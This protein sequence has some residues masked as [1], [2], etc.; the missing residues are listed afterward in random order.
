MLRDRIAQLEAEVA[1]F[2]HPPP[3][4][5][6][7]RAAMREAAA[8]EMQVQDLKEAMAGALE[9]KVYPPV[10]LPAAT[11]QTT[12]LDLTRAFLTLHAKNGECD[13]ESVSSVVA[14]YAHALHARCPGT[15]TAARLNA[16]I[17][18]DAIKIR[19]AQLG[20]LVD[21]H[22]GLDAARMDAAV[23]SGE[24]AR[25]VPIVAHL[26]VG[27][28][29]ATRRNP[30]PSRIDAAIR[31]QLDYASA[32]EVML[33]TGGAGEAAAIDADPHRDP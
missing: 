14:A 6:R 16:I 11:R 27:V 21:Q 4:P 12:A 3:P 23:M 2:E 7:V 17:L 18:P 20:K 8:L 9:A 25:H 31:H 13:F 29:R 15:V 22:F 30:E 5:E 24:P 28:Q 26:L 19:R 32:L 33:L 10:G 1:A